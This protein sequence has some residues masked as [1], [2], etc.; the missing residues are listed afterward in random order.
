MRLRGTSQPVDGRTVTTGEIRPV[1]KDLK[2][3]RPW[4]FSRKRPTRSLTMSSGSMISFSSLP[5]E[6]KK[7]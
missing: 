2:K 6:S 5:M 3:I 1:Y 7:P 4:V